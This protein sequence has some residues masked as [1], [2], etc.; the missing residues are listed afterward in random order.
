[1]I[2]KVSSVKC[3]VLSPARPWSGFRL[4]T[5]HSA[6]GRLRGIPHYSSILSFHHSAPNKPNLG[7]SHFE[8]KCCVDKEL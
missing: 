8:D 4:H 1:M 2:E 3:Q 7:Q 6:E 5:S